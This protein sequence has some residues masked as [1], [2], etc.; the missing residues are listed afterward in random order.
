MKKKI[1]LVATSVL[2]VAAMVIG[3]TLAYFTD[4]DKATNVFTVGNVDI[5]LDE[6]YTQN[7]KLV[8]GDNKTNAVTKEVKVINNSGS[9]KAYVRVHIGIPSALVDA[10]IDSSK[11]ILHVNFTKASVA[12]GL[13]SWLHTYS[14]GA[15]WTDNGLANN[16]T[17]TVE[18]NQIPYTVFVVTYRTALDGGATTAEPAIYQMYIDQH[19]QATKDAEGN[20]IYTRTD[21]GTS[22]NMNLCNKIE[23]VAEGV[24]EA[25]FS[26]AYAALN[27]AFGVPATNN[28]PFTGYLV[29]P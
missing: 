10:N 9:E 8:P 27:A 3:G 2:L 12:D 25:G 6:T 14:T 23:V 19:V 13:W 22:A 16:Q 18:Y 24:Q 17:Y 7:S 15:G 28:N 26:D 1:T 21:I 4:T 11:D 5:T 29:T 20:V